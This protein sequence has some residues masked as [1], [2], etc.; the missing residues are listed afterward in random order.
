M[1][2]KRYNAEAMATYQQKLV[3]VEQA[4]QV[5]RDN[6]NKGQFDLIYKFGEGLINEADIELTSDSLTFA[7]FKNSIALPSK[8]PFEDMV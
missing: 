8:N 5:Y 3:A 4:Q 7:E 6:A 1:M 2:A